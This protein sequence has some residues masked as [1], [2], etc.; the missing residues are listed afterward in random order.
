[1]GSDPNCGSDPDCCPH[2]AHTLAGGADV[3]LWARDAALAERLAA[4]GTNPRLPGACLDPR[5]VVSSD[6]AAT[7]AGALN[8]LL[9][10]CALIGSPDPTVEQGEWLL[11]MVDVVLRGAG[12]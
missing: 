5:V 6:L 10:Q 2:R 8:G 12:K 1:M 9:L 7:V 4:D 11:G 3:T